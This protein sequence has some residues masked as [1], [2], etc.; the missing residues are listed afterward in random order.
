MGDDRRLFGTDGVRDKAGQGLLADDSVRRILEATA[1][2][3]SQPENF[4][5]DFP[6]GRVGSRVLVGRD[7]RDSGPH[8]LKLI[9]QTLGAR[10]FGVVD[11]GVLP[12][13]GVAHL[14]SRAQ[15]AALGIVLSA[16]HNPAADNGVKFFSP[17]GAKVSPEFERAVEEAFARVDAVEV[18][19][20]SDPEDR[21]AQGRADYVDHLVASCWN[22]S[23]L[24]GRRIALDTANGA[25]Y[26]VA[27]EVFRRLGMVVDVIG[28]APD[29]F[30]INAGTG[31]TH[32]EALAE[33]L[34]GEGGGATIGLCF[35]GDGDRMIPITKTGQVLDGDFVIALAARYFLA[36]GRLP[37]KTLVATSMSNIGLELALRD[38]QLQLLRTDVG[39]RNVYDAM[40]AGG[41]PI[42]GEQSGH[43]IFL[44]DAPTG[45]GILSGIRLLDVLQT[46]DLDLDAESAIM[47]R[48][49]Q[50]IQNVEVDEKVPFA[51][52]AGVLEAVQRVEERLGAEG[53]VVLRYSGTEPL[54][55]VM[56]EGPNHE[57][58][59]SSADE[60]CAAIEASRRQY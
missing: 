22:P 18:R 60:I 34:T 43:T 1:R 16:S 15:D 11:V 37:T 6:V 48:F 47:R 13:P 24:R 2:V 21:A 9:A 35:D 5:V 14:A 53:R 45:D 33:R 8:L 56:V 23:R 30:N 58:T 44:D 17:V 31:A 28:D 39:D 41:H 36:N 46:D 57:S 52:L 54:A 38:Q 3:L 49:P 12:T 7:T 29:G 26:R 25:T 50:L 4:P 51:E 27:P 32:P 10:G 40:V 59:Q 20:T 55:R 42:G 19:A